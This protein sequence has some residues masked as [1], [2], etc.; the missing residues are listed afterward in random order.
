MTEDQ[1]LAV[2]TH[3]SDQM[4][5]ELDGVLMDIHRIAEFGPSDEQDEAIT[6]TVLRHVSAELVRRSAKRRI[7]ESLEGQ[8]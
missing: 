8:A 3:I 5:M 4:W 1:N 7:E 6:R 2:L